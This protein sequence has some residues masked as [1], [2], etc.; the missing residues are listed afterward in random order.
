M[1]EGADLDKVAEAC[2]YVGSPCHRVG[3]GP[4]G[5]PPARRPDATV[6]PEELSGRR[7]VVEGWL[8]E[9]I[10]RRQTG[11]WE[12]GF[13]RYVW[14]QHEDTVF[15]ARQGAAGSGLYHGY[16]LQPEQLVRGLE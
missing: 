15:E 7:D 14:Y 3:P 16:P 9:A 1:P 4:E 13:P 8:R 12:G 6:C 5:D 11:V 10:R 2:R